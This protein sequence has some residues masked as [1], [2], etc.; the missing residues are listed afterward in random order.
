MQTPDAVD[1]YL[2]LAPQARVRVPNVAP[3]KVLATNAGGST[4]VRSSNPQGYLIPDVGS[5]VWGGGL[6]GTVRPDTTTIVIRDDG[7]VIRISASEEFAERVFPAL[8]SGNLGSIL[9]T[10]PSQDHV[11]GLGVAGL[12]GSNGLLADMMGI[13]EPAD[14]SMNPHS[15][16]ADLLD[17]PPALAGSPADVHVRAVETMV[18]GVPTPGADASVAEIAT[19]IAEISRLTDG[20]LARVFRVARETFQRWRTGELTN[21]HAANRR[22]LGLLMRLLGDVNNRDV[23]V[24]QWL[25]NVSN[26]E[27]LTP[28]ELLERGRLDDVESLAARIPPAA[29]PVPATADDG[30][31]VTRAAGYPGFGRRSDEPL[32]DVVPDDEEG[33]MEVEAEAIGDDE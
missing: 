30:T 27:N 8:L 25:R 2:H 11:I 4:M 5:L 31:P 12:L 13:G 28:Y 29:A 6:E 1:T 15:V 32:V 18:L 9:V 3:R 7:I 22:R 20:E 23:H 14:A 19:R 33:W 16:I 24:D 21:P 10:H 26:I 17:G